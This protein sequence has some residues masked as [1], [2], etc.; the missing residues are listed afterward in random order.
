MCWRLAFTFALPAAVGS[1]AGTFGSREVSGKALVLAF[2]PV[3]LLAAVLTFA[4][5]GN[6]DE[7]GPCPEP[8]RQNLL[9]GPC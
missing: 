3:M 7:D 4:R 9:P 6:P 2:V 1:L 5:S 8:P